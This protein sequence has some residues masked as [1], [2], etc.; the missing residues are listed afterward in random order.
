VSGASAWALRRPAPLAAVTA[1][2]EELHVHPVLA[3]AIWSR[4]LRDGV[5]ARLLPTLEPLP[6]VGLESATERLALALERGERILLHGDYDA[7]G[8]TGTALLTLGLRALG[9]RV[10]PYLPDR[11][12]DGYGIAPHRVAEH[13]AAADLFVTID[14]GI[15]NLAEVAALRAHGVDAIVTDHH[16]PGDELPDAIVVHPALGGDDDAGT[17]NLTGAGVAYHLL[18]SLHRRLGLEAPTR[19]ADLA[20]IG[21]VADVA[22]LLGANRAL[23]REGLARLQDSAWPGLRALV[24]LAKLR[25]EVTAQQVAFVIAPRLNAAGRLG[26]ADDAF[27]LLVTASEDRARV[28]ATLLDAHNG[29]R[30]ST[31]ER[32]LEQAL[33]LVDVDAPAI[34]LRHADWH[35]GVMGIVASQVLERHYRPVYVVA[36]GKGSVRSTPGISAVGGLRAARAYLRRFGGHAAAAGFALDEAHFEPFRDAVYAYVATHPTPVR[37]A[38]VDALLR[39]EQV[40]AD[41]HAALAAF[42]P[43]GEGMPSPTFAV[44]GPLTHLRSVGEGGRHLQ[45]GVG[46]VRG[47]SWGRGDEASS[48]SLGEPIVAL[49]AVTSSTFRDETRI[50][51]RAAGLLPLGSLRLERADDATP[52]RLRIGPPL[53]AGDGTGSPLRHL[54]TLT[55]RPHDPLADLREA[56]ASGAV[57]H[58]DLDTAAL[59]ALE[60]AAEEYPT[61]HD[62]RVAF[63]QTQRGRPWPFSGRKADLARALLVELELLDER[64]LARRGQRRDPYDAPSLRAALVARYALETLVNLLRTLPPDDA[65]EAILALLEGGEPAE[66]APRETRVIEVTP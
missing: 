57:V 22:P 34:V 20:T 18:W 39:P 45:L 29:E 65:A 42:E 10:T 1:L 48:W 24:A 31:Q 55:P 54:V 51:L 53:A 23:V 19:F 52:H 66:E 26:R 40:T 9:G 56:L 16:V 14:C 43:Y 7:D 27:E 32:M 63:V 5:K 61:L 6:I 33:E 3:A 62:A 30:K 47:V 58:L 28:L 21:T 36:Q 12:G 17:R 44:A 15:S 13:A 8:I 4:G 50:E 37:S 38:L 41:L 11:L 59:S 25:G 35:P 2:T 46:G 64:G 49:A 60:R